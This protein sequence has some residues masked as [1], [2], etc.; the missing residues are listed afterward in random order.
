MS[1]IVERGRKSAGI[2]TSRRGRMVGKKDGAGSP[3]RC[4]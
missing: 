2:D 1:V 4:R 3:Y